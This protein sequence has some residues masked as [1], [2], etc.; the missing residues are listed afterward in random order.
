MTTSGDSRI[1][2]ANSP[3]KANSSLFERL[4][5]GGASK[6]ASAIAPLPVRTLRRSSARTSMSVGPSFWSKLVG[7]AIDEGVGYVLWAMAP[8]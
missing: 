7:S 6:S 8:R 5:L 4:P 2:R 3:T 1:S